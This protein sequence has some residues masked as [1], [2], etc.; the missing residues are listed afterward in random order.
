M[1]KPGPAR[2]SRSCANSS[3]P[4]EGSLDGGRPTTLNAYCEDVAKLRA[5]GRSGRA[6][7]KEVG[8]PAGSVFKPIG[9]VKA[10]ASV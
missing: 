9:E 6:I 5:Q 1:L 3:S 2:C 4:P 10:K 8:I 7:A